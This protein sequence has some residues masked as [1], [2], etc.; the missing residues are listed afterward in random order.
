[1]S[2]RTKPA[3]VTSD[4]D[5]KMNHFLDV[6][7]AAYRAA[8]LSTRRKQQLNEDPDFSDALK[9]LIEKHSVQGH[10]LIDEMVKFYWEVFRYKLDITGLAFP[11]VKGFPFGMTIPADFRD[12]GQ[13]FARIAHHPF[14]VY[15]PYSWGEEVKA[16]IDLG[17]EQKRPSETYC[18]L[19]RGGDTPDECHANE[20]YDQAMKKGFPFL[21]ATEY[22]LIQAFLC[23]S[24]L[25]TLDRH[26]SYTITSSL[27]QQK[28]SERRVITG[29]TRIHGKLSMAWSHT[30]DQ[31]GV[32]EIVIC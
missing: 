21:N 31:F 6:C 23:W 25:Q 28:Q 9:V 4:S 30:G 22:L 8:N 27:W 13:I 7:G 29:T 2:M 14:P 5:G 1:M 18:F 16:G 24:G 19:F 15:L 12:Y 10:T 20:S 26:K 32:R 11:P 17:A 3:L